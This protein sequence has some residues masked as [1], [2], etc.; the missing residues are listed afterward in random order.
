MKTKILITGSAGMVGSVLS[1]YFFS[2]G[3]KIIGVDNLSGGKLQNVL[4]DTLD[5]HFYNC[6]I[7]NTE[8][9]KKIFTRE[10]P[11]FVIHAAAFAAEVLSRHVRSYC[12]QQ[13][14]IGSTNVINCCVNY[15]VKKVL[16]FSSIA[17][18]GD[19]NPP[20]KETDPINPRDI[21][22][23]T[24]IAT[25]WDLREAYDSFG[26]EYSIIT[27]FNII[28]PFQ[29]YFD[30]FRN[31]IAIFIRQTIN[32]EPITIYGDGLQK[33]SFSDCDFICEPIEKLLYSFNGELFNLGS[34]KPITVSEA[35]ELVKKVGQ[36]YDFSPKIVHL[37]ARKE[38][39][40]A[41]CSTEKAQNLLGFKDETNLEKTINKMFLAAL[42]QPLQSLNSYSF[43]ITKN[44]YSFWKK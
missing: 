15:D 8:E 41:W 10:K 35:A 11:D 40:F 2:R 30:K 33:R 27:G 7:L 4:V 21:Y 29:N 25:E 17:R 23:I 1:R 22:A 16:F 34:E 3:Y 20:F 24:K 12:Y 44:L 19:G 39:K 36:T 18:Y 5:T 6:D 9:L 43:E 42:N 31:A 28:S 14:V 38:T 13:N 37:E 26:L 32:G